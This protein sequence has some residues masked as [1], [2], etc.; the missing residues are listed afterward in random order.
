MLFILDLILF[1]LAVVITVLIT[2][3]NSPWIFIAI[4]WVTVSLKNVV[5]TITDRLKKEGK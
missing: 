2:T 3:G 1:A 5:T 4:Y